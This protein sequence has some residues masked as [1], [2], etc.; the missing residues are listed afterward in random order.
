LVFGEPFGVYPFPL[1]SRSKMDAFE[2]SYLSGKIS[3]FAVK[4]KAFTIE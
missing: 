3:G 1:S 4:R 2:E